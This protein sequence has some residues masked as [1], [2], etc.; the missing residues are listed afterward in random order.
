MCS[1]PRFTKHFPSIV[2]FDHHKPDKK[3]SKA[4]IMINILQSKKTKTQVKRESNFLT[5]GKIKFQLKSSFYFFNRSKKG[6]LHG[7]MREESGK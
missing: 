5:N 1:K 6:K 7:H 4:L 2:P 3:K